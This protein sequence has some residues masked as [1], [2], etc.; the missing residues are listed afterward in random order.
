MET[1]VNLYFAR[2]KG[3][4]VYCCFAFAKYIDTYRKFL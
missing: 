4:C 1:R 3:I 2:Y